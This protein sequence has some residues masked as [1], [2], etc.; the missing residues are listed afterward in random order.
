M[1]KAK[2]DRMTA[3]LRVQRADGK[4]EEVFKAKVKTFGEFFELLEQKK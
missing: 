1:K 3:T 4:W 2:D